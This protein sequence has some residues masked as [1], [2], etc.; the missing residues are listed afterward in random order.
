MLLKSCA[1]VVAEPL[2]LIYQA[3]FD[4]G[5]IPQD[6][7]SMDGQC[8]KCCKNITENLSRLSRAL[9]IVTDDRQIDRQTDGR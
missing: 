8:T 6:W 1:G 2:S 3:S 4:V 9:T 5:N 7:M